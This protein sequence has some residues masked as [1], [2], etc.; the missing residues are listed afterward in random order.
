MQQET[1]NAIFL[2]HDL[3]NKISSEAFKFYS[4]QEIEDLLKLVS[5]RKEIA[6]KLTFAKIN[7]QTGKT[8]ARMLLELENNN[9]EI[10]EIVEQPW[11]F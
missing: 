3:C 11:K 9:K 6:N 1:Q 8:A 7:A 10:N 4:N 2:K 5:K